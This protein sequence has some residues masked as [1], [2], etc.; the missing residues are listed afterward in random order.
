MK[1]LYLYLFC[2]SSHIHTSLNRPFSLI[3]TNIK[4]ADAGT[5]NFTVTSAAGCSIPKSTVITVIPKAVINLSSPSV[6]ICRGAA[7]NLGASAPGAISY[8]WIPGR[9]LSDSTIANPV[10]SPTDTTIYKV[11][12][13]NNNGCTDTA[14]LAVNVLPPPVAITQTKQSMFQERPIT[15]TASAKNA[16]VFSWTP[17]TGLSDP[18]VPNPV[19]NPADDITYTLHVKSVYNCGEDTSS[20]FVKVYHKLGVP[21]AFSPNGDG[22]NDSWEIDGLFTYPESVTTVYN[23]Y[24]QQ[25]FTSTGYTKPWRGTY[26]GAKLPPGTY[27]YIIDLKT[28]QPKLTGW[29]VIVN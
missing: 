24:G 8:K 2:T 16:D 10:A 15:L 26:N 25:L 18:N 1:Y 9:G 14:S 4:P 28:G 27:Y 7:A 17:V 12:I 13:T 11:I 5:Y 3:L 23:R 6:T 22:V 29:V 21:T 20:V 19:A